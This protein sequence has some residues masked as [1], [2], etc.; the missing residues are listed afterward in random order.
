MQWDG[1]G[2]QEGPGEPLPSANHQEALMAVDLKPLDQQ[3]IVITGASSGTG[4][5]KDKPDEARL[6][7]ESAGPRGA[8]TTR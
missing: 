5:D 4:G 3:V 7:E 2:A 8:R 1:G 6:M